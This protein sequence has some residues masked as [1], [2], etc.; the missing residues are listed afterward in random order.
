MQN[1]YHEITPEGFGIAIEKDKDLYSESSPYQ[2]VDVFASR[3]F[4]NVWTIM[5]F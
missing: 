4:G 1:L 5:I 3:A 2:K